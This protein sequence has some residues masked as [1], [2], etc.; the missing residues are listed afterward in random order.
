M[1]YFMVKLRCKKS[2]NEI[3]AVSTKKMKIHYDPPLFI[4]ELY[5]SRRWVSRDLSNFMFHAVFRSVKWTHSHRA[6]QWSYTS[7]ARGC[8]Y[9]WAKQP[10]V[11]PPFPVLDTPLP[12]RHCWLKLK[13]EIQHSAGDTKYDFET[14]STLILYNSIFTFFFW[15]LL[16]LKSLKSRTFTILSYNYLSRNSK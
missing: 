13:L 12:F 1:R 16:S 8:N 15:K 6:V 14:I 3:L 4:F 10:S 9:S 2:S 7:R 5:Y 11:L